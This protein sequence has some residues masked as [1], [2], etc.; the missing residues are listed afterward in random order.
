MVYNLI[1]I[2]YRI[3][4]V[5]IEEG[6]SLY[7]TVSFSCSSIYSYMNNEPTKPCYTNKMLWLSED[8]SRALSYGPDVKIFKVKNSLN[9]VNLI[10]N[11][12]EFLN[13]ELDD[14]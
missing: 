6:R 11:I 7:K 8:L 2:I 10:G 14:E 4:T 5:E 9:L 3:D 1:F 12:P 13:E